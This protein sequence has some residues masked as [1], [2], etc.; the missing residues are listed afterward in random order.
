MKV[1]SRFTVRDPKM[2][3]NVQR[4]GWSIKFF[5]HCPSHPNL[6]VQKIGNYTLAD[7]TNLYKNINTNVRNLRCL[8]VLA[9]LKSQRFLI[10]IFQCRYLH[11][12]RI[13]IYIL[14]SFSSTCT[15]LFKLVSGKIL[16]FILVHTVSLKKK[17]MF[18]K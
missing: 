4:E 7:R 5:A 12:P 15:Y 6:L 13:S 17:R 11:L 1:Q 8:G 18:N 16:C 10:I 2:K 9:Y 3:A 14:V